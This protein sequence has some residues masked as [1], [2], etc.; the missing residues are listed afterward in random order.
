MSKPTKKT[1]IRKAAIKKTEEVREVP[2]KLTATGNI[3]KFIKELQA[4]EQSHGMQIDSLH[5]ELRVIAIKSPNKV[6]AYLG[7]HQL[8]LSDTLLEVDKELYDKTF[9][10]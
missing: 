2:V 7:S 3:K 9:G 4:I 5:D 1:S 10:N 8:V 6:L